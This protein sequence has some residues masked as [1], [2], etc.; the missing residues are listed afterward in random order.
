MTNATDNAQAFDSKTIEL[1][2][3]LSA[4][5]MRPLVTQK[6]YLYVDADTLFDY[7]LGAIMASIK[8]EHDYNYV[9]EHVDE[10]LTAP[11]L[12]C[13]KFF[14]AFNKTDAELDDIASSSAGAVALAALT[15]PT[16]VLEQLPVIIRV[17]N[18]INLSKETQRPIH[19]TINQRRVAITDYIKQF[20]T[21]TITRGD[22][23]AK[24]DF[25][26]YKSWFDVPEDL[27]RC[28]DVII[29]YDLKEF[30]TLETT[31]QKLLID[32]NELAMTDIMALTQSELSSEDTA[33][34]LENMKNVMELM[35]DKFTFINKTLLGR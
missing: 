29:V 20:I 19:V 26:S 7:R 33:L 23:S 1:C 11:T 32:T 15:P 18:T 5:V 34:G 31:S 28:Q 17:L 25:T 8:N 2:D 4:E 30:L 35:C 9:L 16:K 10:Y 13:A 6:E 24:I 3:R 12:E 22:A 14:P 27:L 21:D